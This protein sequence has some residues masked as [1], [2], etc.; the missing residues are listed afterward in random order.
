M[1][2]CPELETWD[3]SPLKPR[4]RLCV[5]VWQGR[6]LGGGRRRVAHPASTATTRAALPGPHPSG[7]GGSR[8]IAALRALPR[9]PALAAARALRCTRCHPG[10]QP[11]S[12]FQW[13]R[14]KC[15]L[16]LKNPG[17]VFAPASDAENYTIDSVWRFTHKRQHLISFKPHHNCDRSKA[18]S[19][20]CAF[21][22]SGRSNQAW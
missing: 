18:V 8:R 2:E 6:T 19:F 11:I 13:T 1:D 12:R 4:N 16:G 22:R 17:G 7:Q 14:G 10:A 3:T 9:R 15:L 21:S 5:R 20:S